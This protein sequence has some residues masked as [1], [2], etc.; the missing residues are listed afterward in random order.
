MRTRPPED[1][2]VN[3]WVALLLPSSIQES[4]ISE[5]TRECNSRTRDAD[6]KVLNFL[7][8]STTRSLLQGCGR[9][10]FRWYKLLVCVTL[11]CV[12]EL[13]KRSWQ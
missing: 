12:A 5:I 10:F 7:S 3:D 4:Q 1:T 9:Y 11:G 13:E 8:N 2:G 6:T